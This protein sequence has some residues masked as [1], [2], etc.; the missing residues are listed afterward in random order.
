[1]RWGWL[2]FVLPGIG[3]GRTTCDFTTS[4]LTGEPE[5]DIVGTYGGWGRDSP[6]YFDFIGGGELREIEAPNQF[7]PGGSEVGGAWDIDGELLHMTQGTSIST[8][9]FDVSSD[10]L[11]VEEAPEGTAGLSTGEHQRVTC[12][13]FGFDQGS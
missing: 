4:T 9:L 12:T 6:V 5:V 11:T 3:C 2:M 7:R 8:F 13:G 1:M 10:A